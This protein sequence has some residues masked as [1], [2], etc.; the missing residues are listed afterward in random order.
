MKPAKKLP[1]GLARSVLKP[2]T[3]GVTI[4]TNGRIDAVL[5]QPTKEIDLIHSKRGSKCLHIWELEMC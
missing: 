5:I 3:P 1:V 2:K 4:E